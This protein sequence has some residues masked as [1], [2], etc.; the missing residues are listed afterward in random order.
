MK[1]KTLFLMFGL[2]LI[3]ACT[4]VGPVFSPGEPAT[5]ETLPPPGL[6]MLTATPDLNAATPTI[7]PPTYFFFEPGVNPLTGLPVSDPAILERRPVMVKVS[8]WPREG[9]PHAG[10]SQ[11]DLVFE[12]YIGFQMNRFVAVYYGEDSEW[13]GPVRSGR[14]VDAQLANLYQ[15]LLGYGNADPQVDEVIL[16]AIGARALAFN[17]LPCPAMCGT[18]TYA[19]TGVHANSS[20]LTDHA[21]AIGVPNDMPDLRGMYFQDEIPA[22]GEPGWTLRVEYANFSIMQWYYDEETADY[23]LW[24]EAE[25]GGTLI[26][27]PM[28]D[29]NNGQPVAFDNLVV[30]FAE[31]VEYAPS[32]HDILIEGKYTL[33]DALL[34]RDGQ[35]IRGTWRTPDPGRPVIFET[36]DGGPMPL[37]PGRTWVVIAGLNSQISWPEEG[38]WRID[39]LIP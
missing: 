34:F 19:A 39:F 4:T 8:N 33:Q 37:K 9:R 5:T 7:H 21:L 38:F 26:L 16:D 25:D 28:N 27:A 31:Y 11:A 30:M 17:Y 10:L 12:Y 6:T 2:L 3:A 23:H 15:G 32:L 35:V 24:M 20:A 18:S 14:L 1:I 13:I 29:R 22:N 36:L